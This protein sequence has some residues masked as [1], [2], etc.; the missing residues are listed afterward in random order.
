MDPLQMMHINKL[1]L[2]NSLEKSV[3]YCKKSLVAL[4]SH[5]RKEE[6]NQM[7]CIQR[8]KEKEG[9]LPNFPSYFS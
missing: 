8:L 5:V 1:L 4:P 3:C 2:K 9:L 7:L 6:I